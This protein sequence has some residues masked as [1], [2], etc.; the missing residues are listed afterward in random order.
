M[1]C[2]VRR[3]NR[4]PESFIAWF[5]VLCHAML[6]YATLW[7]TLVCFYF[8]LATSIQLLSITFDLTSSWI[9]SILS[10]LFLCW[11]VCMCAF[12]SSSFYFLVS[13][14]FCYFQF[15]HFKNCISRFIF[16]ALPLFSSYSKQQTFKIRVLFCLFE[17]LFIH[18]WCVL[19]VQFFASLQ[20]FHFQKKS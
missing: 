8:S 10:C 12:V 6:C 18:R 1:P 4:Q 20:L 11:L 2:I 5:D 7:C 9:Y 3:C 19:G 13:F 16:M 17:C 15:Q 14:S